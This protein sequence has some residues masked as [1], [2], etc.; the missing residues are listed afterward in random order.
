MS[1]RYFIDKYITRWIIISIDSLIVLLSFLLTCLL[2]NDFRLK[3]LFQ[4]D[5]LYQVPVIM[6]S[7]FIGFAIFKPYKAYTGVSGIRDIVVI[8]YS[9]FAGAVCIFFA[10]LFI[11][12]FL[13]EKLHLVSFSVLLTDVAVTLYMMIIT[14]LIVR[15]FYKMIQEGAAKKHPLQSNQFGKASVTTY[16]VELM[17]I[18]SLN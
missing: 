12:L 3:T 17:V 15:F 18:N 16:P 10:N 4:A 7:Y 11:K 2:M 14:R 5:I 13:S 1:Y 6:V 9:V 8:F